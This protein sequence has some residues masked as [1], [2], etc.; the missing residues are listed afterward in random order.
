MGRGDL[1]PYLHANSRMADDLAD[2]PTSLSPDE[3][4]AVNDGWSRRGVQDKLIKHYKRRTW[5]VE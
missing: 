4:E 1:R 3:S 2:D 5:S